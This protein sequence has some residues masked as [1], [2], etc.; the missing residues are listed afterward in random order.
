MDRV[1]SL[2][3]EIVKLVENEEGAWAADVKTN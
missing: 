1:V 2:L 3:L